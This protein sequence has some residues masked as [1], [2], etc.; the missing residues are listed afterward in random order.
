MKTLHLLRHAKSSW[1]D[2]NCPD[3]D[4]PLNKRGRRDAPLMGAALSRI[5][6]P[7][8]VSCSTARRAGLTLEGLC[9]GWAE[10]AALRHQREEALYTFDADEVLAWIMAQDDRRG[11]L[12]IIG[13]NPALTDLANMLCGIL[14]SEN[15]PTA[16]YVRLGL[17]IGHWRDA[18]PDSARLEQVLLP[19]SLR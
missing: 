3:R 7:V 8:P 10:L 6:P 13:H 15:I 9:D 11:E 5:V 17:A 4:R 16:G 12:F 2:P 14:V 1:S 18:A 19:R